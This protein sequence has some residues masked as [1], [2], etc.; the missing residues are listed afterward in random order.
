MQLCGDSKVVGKWINGKYSLGQKYPYRRLTMEAD[1]RAILGAEGQ[2]IIV[3]DRGSD[4][5]TWKALKGFWDGGA[6]DDGKSGCGIVAESVRHLDIRV[7]R[8]M[9]SVFPKV[10]F[11]Q[12]QVSALN[13]QHLCATTGL[14][15]AKWCDR[16]PGRSLAGSGALPKG[17]AEAVEAQVSMFLPAFSRKCQ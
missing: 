10:S 11:G 5:E 12:L 7:L 15:D 14:K 2:R 3:I 17:G 16:T 9:S 1:H 8:L 6:K 4:S 13:P